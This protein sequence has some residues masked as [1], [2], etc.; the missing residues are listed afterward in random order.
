MKNK[1]FNIILIIL[2]QFN[3]IYADLL[4][5][6]NNTNLNFTHILFEWEQIEAAISYELQISTND[7][8]TNVV[9]NI[10]DSSLIY[11]EKNNLNWDNTYYWRIRSIHNNETASNWSDY[12]SFTINN[13]ISNAEATIYEENQYSEENQHF[14]L[15][16]QAA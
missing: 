10:I 2:F 8:F 3:S 7:S 1:L 15:E 9:T 14:L 13:N 5:P 11:I 4:K 16:N 6:E 12:Y